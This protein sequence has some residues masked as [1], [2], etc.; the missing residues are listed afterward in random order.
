MTVTSSP[1]HEV[2]QLLV[3]WSNGDRAALDR[4]M[5][6]VYT[7]LRRLAHHYMRRERPGHTLQTTALVNEAYLRLVDQESMRWENRA[8][9]FGIA[10]RL[11][12]EILVDHARSQQ[13][14][15]RGGGQYKLS[16]SKVDRIA[17]RPDVN[18][19]ALDEALGRLE[20]NDPQKSRIVELR[21]FG[22]LGIEET[23][24]VIGISPAT[25]KRDWSMARAWLRSEIGDE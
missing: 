11:M 2:T 22:G 17:S 12:R 9:F 21:Y 10:A 18:L 14:A 15:K 8:H 23:A 16:L 4:L 7:E 20:A 5:P 1:T 19:I 3:A 24:E 25:V 13:A 6:L